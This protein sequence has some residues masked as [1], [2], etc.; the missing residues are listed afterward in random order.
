M[1][2]SENDAIILCYLRRRLLQWEW[3]ARLRRKLKRGS[4]TPG[5]L[6]L[7]FTFALLTFYSQLAIIIS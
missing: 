7:C 2:S 1:V 3:E 6:F 4:G 5:P